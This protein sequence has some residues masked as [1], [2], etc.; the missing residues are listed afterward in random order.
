MSKKNNNKKKARM[1]PETKDKLKTGF[2]T[3]V[4]NDAAIKAAREYHWW[5]PVI[6][7]IASVI[8]TLV[9]SFVSNM[10][11]NMG[12]TVLAAGGT[13][14]SNGLA[15]FQLEMKNKNV[16]IKIDEKGNLIN[17]KASFDKLY[18]AGRNEITGD[19]YFEAK[20]AVTGYPQLRVL[21][22]DDL[23]SQTTLNALSTYDPSKFS[24]I[25][26]SEGATS[27]TTTTTSYRVSASTAYDG[28]ESSTGEGSE[29]AT[30]ETVAT[31]SY[32]VSVLA[33]K[34]TGFSFASYPDRSTATT[35]AF[36]SY[37]YD[38]IKGKS[39]SALSSEKDFSADP[40]A[41][42]SEVRDN[43]RALLT[44][45]YET[46]KVD[47][48]WKNVGILTG[49]NAGIILL[50]GL[51]LFLITRGKNNPYR[52]ITFWQSQ[53]IAYWEAM[54]PAILS[55]ALGFLLSQ[56]MSS[57]TMFVFLFLYGLRIMWTSMKAFSP[58]GK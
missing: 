47:L 25:T 57:M 17:D 53:K 4:N 12:Q 50:L 5:M 18:N 20:D 2:L 56:S 9:P 15:K 32:R 52:V 31:A 45:G 51:V 7:A 23:I 41:Y 40:Q 39:L 13:S 34:T 21:F 24:S 6:L 11:V 16:D 29:G 46:T 48:A 3:L 19:Y 43:Y 33:F 8:I 44:K 27:E 1:S 26:N 42:I 36:V 38:G 14:I 49:I 35:N 28:G 30:S 55:L 54:A 22:T 58:Q 37:S 10:Q